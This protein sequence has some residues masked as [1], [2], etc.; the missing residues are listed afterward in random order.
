MID[1]SP[2]SANI[3][4]H[5]GGLQ[6]AAMIEL[7]LGTSTIGGRTPYLIHHIER[8]SGLVETALDVQ[9]SSSISTDDTAEVGKS[10]CVRK[11]FVINLDWS[12]VGSV[13]CHNFSLLAADVQANLLCKGVEAMRLLLYVGVGV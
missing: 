11:L 10:V 6:D 5:T 9:V 12:C 8:I 1:P 7:Q 13:Q 2:L 4:S 3:L